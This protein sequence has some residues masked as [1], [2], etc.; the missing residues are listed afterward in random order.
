ML[1]LAENQLPDIASKHH[2]PRAAT[3]ERLQDKASRTRI[4][5]T[6]QAIRDWEIP[7]DDRAL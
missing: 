5:I 3:D 7:H 4:K 6:Q 1:E 2:Q